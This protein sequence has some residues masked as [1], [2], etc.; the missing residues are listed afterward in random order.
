MP[1]HRAGWRDSLTPT[2]II[3]GYAPMTIDV[4]C[5]N[6]GLYAIRAQIAI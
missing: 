2:P 4:G 6:A 5:R 3:A 1:G